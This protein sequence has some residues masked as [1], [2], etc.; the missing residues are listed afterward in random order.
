MVE[1]RLDKAT[2]RAVLMEINGR[3]WGSFPLAVQC[4][5]GFALLAYLTNGI[6]QEFKLE[7]VR[8]GLRCRM[9]A[10]EIKRLIRILFQPRKIS[11]P[12]FVPAPGKELI[13]FCTDFFRT[14]IGYYVWDMDDPKPFWTDLTNM[15]LRR[16]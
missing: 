9:M 1:Y 12:F 15:I 8:T 11:D 7:E 4:G 3:F 14:G 6:T 16:S 5:A 13:L 2:G 10:T